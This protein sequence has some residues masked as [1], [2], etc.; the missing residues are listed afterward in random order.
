M[1]I[2]Y[3]LVEIEHKDGLNPNQIVPKITSGGNIQSVKVLDVD[4]PHT[5]DSVPYIAF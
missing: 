3:V 2:A 5:D 4:T 1:A